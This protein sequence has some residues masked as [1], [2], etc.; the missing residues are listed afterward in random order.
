MSS[1]TQ[2][3]SFNQAYIGGRF[4][5]LHGKQV[6]DLV[7]PANNEVLGKVA[8]ADEIDTRKHLVRRR[9]FA[10]GHGD[11]LRCSGSLHAHRVD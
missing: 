7:N 9:Q 1:Q 10:N 4:V 3:R 11:F 6:I 5:T 8:L 2:Q